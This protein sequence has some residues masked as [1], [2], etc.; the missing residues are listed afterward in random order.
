MQRRRSYPAPSL[1]RPPHAARRDRVQRRALRP[2]A[3]CTLRSAPCRSS[4][5]V[6]G[7]VA[8]SVPG[9]AVHY[10]LRSFVKGI[11]ALDCVVF[12]A[13]LAPSLV[14]I[15]AARPSLASLRP[16]LLSVL[17]VLLVLLVL[18]ALAFASISFTIWEDRV[19][20]Y[21]LL[22]YVILAG[23]SAPTVHLRYR[24]RGFSVLFAGCVRA[25]AASMVCREEQH[26]Y[27]HVT[28]PPEPPLLILILV[29]AVPTAALGRPWAVRRFLQTSTSENG[30]AGIVLPWLLPIVLL[31]SPAHWIA[32]WLDTADV[33]GRK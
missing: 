7:I 24:I 16:S 30:V 33:L 31:Q 32:E 2:S 12:R 25:M 27:C 23:F 19:I 29:L 26:P 4:L 6:H 21:L 9:F 20:T 22:S 14:V 13:P 11:D 17:L 8:G 28:L 1:L 3:L 15:A 18:H 10:P 5:C